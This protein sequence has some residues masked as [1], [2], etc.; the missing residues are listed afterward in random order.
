MTARALH[1]LSSSSG[2]SSS[3]G[4]DADSAQQ[5][6]SPSPTAAAFYGLNHTLQGSPYSPKA[7]C[8]T[9]RRDT[10]SE[11]GSE[12]GQAGTQANNQQGGRS[13]SGGSTNGRASLQGLDA[14][15][16]PQLA[17]ERTGTR[18]Q[19]IQGAGV[20]VEQLKARQRSHDIH[21]EGVLPSTT[22]EGETKRAQGA[23]LSF[24]ASFLLVASFACP[25]TP[26]PS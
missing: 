2:S 18:Q 14:A 9:V 15:A 11:G 25:A 7:S 19:N 16:G 6:A 23:C 12:P 1:R 13:S 20:L 21:A 5:Q 10:G 4:D 22:A 24:S 8:P 3:S 17:L 26:Q